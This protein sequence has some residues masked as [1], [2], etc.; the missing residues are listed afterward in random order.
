MGTRISAQ[1]K[2]TALL[3]VL[4]ITEASI[5]VAGATDEG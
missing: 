4:E 3:E 5:K 1:L 2:I